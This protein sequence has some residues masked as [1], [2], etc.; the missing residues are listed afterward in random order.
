[1]SAKPSAE[2]TCPHNLPRPP[3]KSTS[4]ISVVFL[5]CC[6]GT[7]GVVNKRVTVSVRE[8]NIVSLQALLV[9]L[10]HSHVTKITMTS[11]SATRLYH[12]LL[13]LLFLTAKFLCWNGST[14]KGIGCPS[15]CELAGR[16]QQSAL[17]VSFES[18]PTNQRSSRT[19]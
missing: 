13:F 3:D 10:L 15:R 4:G 12:S 18:S 11:P 17:P 6:V 8:E 19:A 14:A 2:S 7:M 5:L 1:M 9:L 16:D